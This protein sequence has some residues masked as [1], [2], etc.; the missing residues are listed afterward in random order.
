MEREPS[1]L[2][3]LLITLSIY[4][5]SIPVGLVP[6]VGQILAI[7]LVP[8][9]ASA[10]GTRWADPKERLPLAISCSIIWSGIVTLV[11]VL[12][13]KNV[14]SLSPGGFKMDGI[15]W[16]LIIILWVFIILFTILGALFPW[17]DPFG[18]T[19]A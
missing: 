10:L 11:L 15:A 1:F 18:E 8:Y 16:G 7:T 2:K 9:L 12:V 19:D 13:M 17:R 14:S 5:F 3:G 4:L 6:I